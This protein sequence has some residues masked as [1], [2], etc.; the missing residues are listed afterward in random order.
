MMQLICFF[1][2]A[3][4][5]VYLYEKNAG[6]LFSAKRFFVSYITFAGIINM[7]CLGAVAVLLHHPD[8]VLNSNMISIGFSFKYLLLGYALAAVLPTAYGIIKKCLQIEFSVE[9][10][11][12]EKGDISDGK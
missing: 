6:E 7:L 12:N 9:A 8:Y 10:E 11:G 2:P 4:L 1:A 3:F 5:A